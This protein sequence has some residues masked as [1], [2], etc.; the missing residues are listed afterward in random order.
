MA[1]AILR[2]LQQ[3]SDLWRSTSYAGF[4]KESS[5]LDHTLCKFAVWNFSLASSY[6]VFWLVI[7]VH[8]FW[9]GHKILKIST[10]LLSYVVQVKSKVE[11]SQNIDQLNEGNEWIL[12]ITYVSVV[13][14]SHQT[15]LFCTQNTCIALLS[16]V[17]SFTQ[18]KRESLHDC[19]FLLHIG[20]ISTLKELFFCRIFMLL[21]AIHFHQYFCYNAIIP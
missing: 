21:Y 13:R 7:K 20:M 19:A 11:I 2:L 18:Q 14:G 12:V 4:K 15:L 6:E 17:D 5:Q 9:K 3:L 8:I 1:R 16:R 10:L